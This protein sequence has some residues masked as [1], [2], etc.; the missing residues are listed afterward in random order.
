MKDRLDEIDAEIDA[1]KE[2]YPYT[3]RAPYT[4]I[5][6]DVNANFV[7]VPYKKEGY[8]LFMFDDEADRDEYAARFEDKPAELPPKRKKKYAA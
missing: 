6:K 8:A 4:G 5:P 2:R 3:F 7:W 1:R